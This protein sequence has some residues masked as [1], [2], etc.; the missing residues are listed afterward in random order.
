MQRMRRIFSV[1]LLLALA[2]G[3]PAYSLHLGGDLPAAG[4]MA[5]QAAPDDCGNCGTEDMAMAVCAIAAG[6]VGA[7]APAFHT[8]AAPAALASAFDLMPEER[9]SS[10]AGGPDPFPP[11]LTVL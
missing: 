6:C 9:F 5:D 4:T 10:S 2:L 3:T 7:T 11:K 1:F 8:S